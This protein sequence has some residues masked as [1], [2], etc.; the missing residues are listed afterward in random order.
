MSARQ[1][2]PYVAPQTFEEVGSTNRPPIALATNS[3]GTKGKCYLLTKIAKEKKHLNGSECGI[4]SDE[5]IG[6]LCH[7]RACR[8]MDKINCLFPFRYTPSKS[9]MGQHIW[10]TS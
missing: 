10:D 5:N 8:T 9:Y 6:G 1:F 2:D 4:A 7:Y 3:M